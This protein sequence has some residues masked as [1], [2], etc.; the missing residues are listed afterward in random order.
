VVLDGVPGGHGGPPGPLELAALALA[1]LALAHVR[2]RV[3]VRVLAH[4]HGGHRRHGLGL[5]AGAFVI[6]C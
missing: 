5:A 4:V 3:A 6:E 2:V 1:A